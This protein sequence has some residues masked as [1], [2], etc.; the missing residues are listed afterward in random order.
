[1]GVCF[2]PV[3][4]T[5]CGGDQIV[6]HFVSACKK[7]RAHQ[8]GQFMVLRGDDVR[9]LFVPRPPALSPFR[10][11]ALHPVLLC[12]LTLWLLVL[13]SSCRCFV[14]SFFSSL[15]SFDVVPFFLFFFPRS[16]SRATKEI[17]RDFQNQMASLPV[18]R[19]NVTFMCRSRC[20]AASSC[21]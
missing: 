5:R 2:Q 17:Y 4:G 8:E 10:S 11:S 12:P 3:W 20:V 14:W 9:T 18:A 21:R 19:R 16:F 13:S 1:M 6:Y 7:T 15:V